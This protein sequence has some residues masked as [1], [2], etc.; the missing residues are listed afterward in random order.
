MVTL[1]RPSFHVYSLLS[2]RFNSSLVDI[3]PSREHGNGDGMAVVHNLYKIKT[4]V[5][6][7]NTVRSMLQGY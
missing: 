1:N 5:T 7:K 2:I 3:N 4:H 6:F